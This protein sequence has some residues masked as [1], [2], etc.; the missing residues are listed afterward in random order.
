VS[1]PQT[2]TVVV[3]AGLLHVTPARVY[4]LCRAGV[5]PHVRLGRQVRI[6]EDELEAFIRG[7]GRPLPPRADA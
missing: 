4:E 6:P 2:L 5:L 7:G 3:A 1:A